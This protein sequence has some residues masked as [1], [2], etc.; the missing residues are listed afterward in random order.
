MTFNPWYNDSADASKLIV[1]HH[2]QEVRVLTD[3]RI[4]YVHQANCPG[5]RNGTVVPSPVIAPQVSKN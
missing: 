4:A 3:G 1:Q 2:V 5:C